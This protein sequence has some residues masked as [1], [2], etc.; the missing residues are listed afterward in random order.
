MAVSKKNRIAQKD[1]KKQ[2]H[3]NHVGFLL[4]AAYIEGLPERL[5]NHYGLIQSKF[6]ILR[7]R[8]YVIWLM[9]LIT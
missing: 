5:R 8:Y 2:Q 7:N 9:R 6:W 4:Q 1:R 3:F